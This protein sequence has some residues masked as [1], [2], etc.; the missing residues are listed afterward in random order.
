[1][2]LKN[3]RGELSLTKA[4]ELAGISKSYLSL[5][6][7]G[8]RRMT[9]DLAEKLGNTYGVSVVA[10]LHAYKVCRLSTKQIKSNPTGTDGS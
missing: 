5:L 2:T 4:A 6:E 7:N 8:K 1:M 9:L 3:L 10:I